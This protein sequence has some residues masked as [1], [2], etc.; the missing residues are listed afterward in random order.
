MSGNF[1]V[2]HP[3]KG[4]LSTF[5]KTEDGY[6]SE[7]YAAPSGAQTAVKSKEKTIGI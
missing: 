1:I 6:L 7:V 4:D 3:D 5:P 2:L